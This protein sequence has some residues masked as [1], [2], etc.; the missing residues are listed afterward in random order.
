MT[1]HSPMSL[2]LRKTLNF[3]IW[4]NVEK[5]VIFLDLS[6]INEKLDGAK[7]CGLFCLVYSVIENLSYSD[8]IDIFQIARLQQIRRPQ[9]FSVE[10][11]HFCYNI[12]EEYL[13]KV[14]FQKIYFLSPLQQF[15]KKIY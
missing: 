13:E 2:M 15:Y 3:K 14:H 10:Q 1:R 8:D 12:V 11:Y 9:F 4:A 5:A 6:V 7:C